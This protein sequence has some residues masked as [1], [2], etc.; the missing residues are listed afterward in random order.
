MRK[1]IVDCLISADF[2]AKNIQAETSLV[3]S[4]KASLISPQEDQEEANKSLLNNNHSSSFSYEQSIYTQALYSLTP[5]KVPHLFNDQSEEIFMLTES[6]ILDEFLFWC[7]KFDFQENLLNLLLSL[8]PDIRYKTAFTKSFVS[9]YS[10]ISVLLLTS[11]SSNILSSKVIHI[12]VQLFSNEAI[13]LKAMEEFHLLPIILST[14]YNM[15]VTPELPEGASLLIKN[16]LEDEQVNEHMV[17]NPE[18]AILKENL[19]FQIVNDFGNLLTHK[20]IA[21]S[22]MRNK[23]LTELWFELIS[24]F[25]SMNLIVRQFS[26]HSPL[27]PDYFSSFTA[28]S[29][30]CANIMWS[31]I[32]YLKTSDQL[33]ITSALLSSIANQLN[34]WF[35][36]IGLPRQLSGSVIKR[37]NFKHLSFH[38][39]LNRYFSTILHNALYSQGGNLAK[40]LLRPEIELASHQAFL[41]NLLTYPLQ[42]QIGFHEIFANM[43]HLNGQQMQGQAMTYIQSHFSSSFID[44][45]LFLL[46]A[47]AS[48]LDPTVFMNLFF[49]RFH[50]TKWLRS[51]IRGYHK[52]QMKIQTAMAEN[53]QTS[54][55]SNIDIHVSV[56][57]NIVEEMLDEFN[58]D[59]SAPSSL[60]N[61]A[62]ILNIIQDDLEPNQQTTMLVGAL[63][64]L[65]QILMIRPNLRQES[66]M[67]TRNEI[68]SILSMSDRTFSQI[69]MNLPDILSQ[70]KS[71]KFIEP[72]LNEISDYL[73]P[74]L[75]TGILKQGRYK[76]KD[77]IWIKEYDPLFVMLRS[78]RRRQFQDSYDR[79]FQFVQRKLSRFAKKN[80]WPPFKL[81]CSSPPYASLNNANNLAACSSNLIEDGFNLAQ[82]LANDRQLNEEL[83]GRW[84]LLDTKILHAILITVL[85]EVRNFISIFFYGYFKRFSL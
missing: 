80:L 50:L 4:R 13:A 23:S 22:F 33:D 82:E 65:A 75:D 58:S 12:S 36:K 56:I 81:P 42:L 27:D 72:I 57:S 29:E 83:N 49:E 79:Y 70:N 11:K 7:I 68:V 35:D 16:R 73:K 41:V 8:L 69:G 76:L 25:Q 48:E 6:N 2:Y 59:E 28:E 74:S 46:Q 34:I 5:I 85:Y 40:L 66:Y 53:R 52:E 26:E 1:L 84:N 15:I 38:Y 30:I 17:V 47:I 37:P 64:V 44:A 51:T 63:T 18:N 78:V 62:S 77:K 31:F 67:L 71:N 3:T 54:G 19:Y 21:L 32:Q 14:L 43:W 10:Y 24:Y 60:I 61:D 39:P 9:K 20:K 45:D 55:N